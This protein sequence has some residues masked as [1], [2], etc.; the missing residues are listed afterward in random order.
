MFSSA[1]S[2][3]RPRLT[4]RMT[5]PNSVEI[6]E[7]GP[8]AQRVGDQGDRVGQLLVESIEA[9][10]LP[11]AQPQAWQEEPDQRADQQHDRVAQGGHADRDH[12]HQQRHA[13]DA[14]GPDHEVLADLEAQIRPRDLARE[15]GPEVSLL[16]DLVERRHGLAGLQRLGQADLAGRFRFL[17]SGRGIALE[18]GVDARAAA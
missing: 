13:H 5:R 1:V 17:R 15:V 16:D 3:A 8:G 11:P 4:S 12:D 9:A 7:R 6:E 14:G 10:R 2:N 18:S